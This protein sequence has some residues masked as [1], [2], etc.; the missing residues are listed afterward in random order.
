[1]RVKRKKTKISPQ[2]KRKIPSQR[3]LLRRASQTAEFAEEP[4]RSHVLSNTRPLAKEVDSL[5]A[6]T[7]VERRVVGSHSVEHQSCSG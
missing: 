2:Q 3:L 5:P 1:M 7:V 4:E 6:V